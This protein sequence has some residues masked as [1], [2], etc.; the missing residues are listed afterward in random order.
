MDVG[1][2]SNLN[3]FILK[4]G[5]KSNFSYLSLISN[6][7]KFYVKNSALSPINIVPYISQNLILSLK[8]KGK[9]S[10]YCTLK[11][12]HSCRGS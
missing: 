9:F 7:V 8:I 2:K 5:D 12:P 10:L 1:D 11:S 3:Y 4:I 6:W